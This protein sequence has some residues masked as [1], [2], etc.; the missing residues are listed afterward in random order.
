MCRIGRG[1]S[2]VWLGA[3]D[4]VC[5]VLSDRNGRTINWR[6]IQPNT[7]AWKV[8]A[9]LLR[10]YG[11]L[12]SLCII[13]MYDA[14]AIGPHHPYMLAP[15]H[16]FPYSVASRSLVGRVCWA[17]RH[18]Q[19]SGE[20]VFVPLLVC[21]LSFSFSLSFSLSLFCCFKPTCLVFFM[22]CIGQK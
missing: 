6:G 9:F 17:V 21:F 15:A 5:P 7:V 3:L 12:T 14:I 11:R 19:E 2:G 20:F 10:W 13:G 4:V 8:F 18:N 22:L 16:S 1:W